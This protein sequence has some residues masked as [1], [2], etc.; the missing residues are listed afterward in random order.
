MNG[1][2]LM[3]P[4]QNKNSLGSVKVRKWERKKLKSLTSQE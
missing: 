1:R 3:D 4:G 2:Y